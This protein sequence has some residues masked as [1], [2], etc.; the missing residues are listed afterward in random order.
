MGNF[1]SRRGAAYVNE[2]NQSMG[3][4]LGIAQGLLADKELRDSEIAFLDQWLNAHGA[5]CDAW[6][7]DVVHARVIE[8][9]ANGYVTDEERSHLI[10]TLQQLVGGTLEQLANSTHVTQLLP[11]ETPSIAYDGTFFCLTGDFACGPRGSCEA[12]ITALGG[13]IRSSVSKKLNYLVVGGLGSPEWKHGSF[14]TKVEKAM[15]LKREG[16]PIFLVREEH[17]LTS[18]KAAG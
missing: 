11:Y 14:G 9:L 8:A 3:A 7:G 15:E 12:R 4:L 13:E 1:F 17:W 6:P 5:L 10:S 2:L 16:T 18:L